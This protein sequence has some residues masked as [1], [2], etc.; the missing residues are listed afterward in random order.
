MHFVKPLSW[1]QSQDTINTAIDQLLKILTI[2]IR[3]HGGR[4]ECCLNWNVYISVNCELK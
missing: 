3:A 2:M 1:D 4:T